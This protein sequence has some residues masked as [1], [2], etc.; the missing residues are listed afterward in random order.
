MDYSIR[1]LRQDDEPFLWEMLYEAAH[2]GEEGATVQAVKK[3]PE[4][5]KYVEGWGRV[6]DMGCV[7]TL[8]NSNQP[9]GAAWLRLLTGDNKGYGYVNDATPELA[10]AVVPEHRGKGVG[11]QLLAHLLALAK[12][13]YPSVSLSTRATNPALHLYK[14]MGFKI[15]DGSDVINRTG[16]TSLT[17]KVDF[18]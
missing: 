12:D 10:I 9:I 8:I 1:L 7:A 11:T 18:L 6:G 5:A 3:H 15:I 2:L 16:S 14:R 17:M 13:S 4:I